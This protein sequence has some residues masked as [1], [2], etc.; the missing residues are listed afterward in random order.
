MRSRSAY[1]A[2][3]ASLTSPLPALTPVHTLGSSAGRLAPVAT[4]RI[5]ARLR[6][7]RAWPWLRAVAGL[8]V[9]SR[10]CSPGLIHDRDGRRAVDRPRL[11]VPPGGHAG[12]GVRGPGQER[13][14][15]V[16]GGDVR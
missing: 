3:D 4:G 12:L 11:D 10:R 1:R 8:P 16:T 6:G 2:P 14:A 13:M 15:P 9:D 7:G 5:P